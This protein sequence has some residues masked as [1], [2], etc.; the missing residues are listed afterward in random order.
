VTPEGI[1][2][3]LKNAK[4]RMAN[5]AEFIKENRK[6]FIRLHYMDGDMIN[7]KLCLPGRDCQTQ[8]P[9]LRNADGEITY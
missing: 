9:L 8:N 1:V 7:E 3:M 4:E 6:I 5:D 2:Q